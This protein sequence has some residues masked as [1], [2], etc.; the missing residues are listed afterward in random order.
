MAKPHR[1][2]RRR[3]L[4][5][6]RAV[7]DVQSGQVRDQ[8]LKIKERFQP[9]LG[10]FRLIGRVSRV[11]AGVFQNGPL[12][13][14]WGQGAVVTLADVAAKELVLRSQRSELGEG[15]AFAQSSGKVE[16]L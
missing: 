8:R 4:V 11:P 3:C 9:T 7:G 13:H 12:N 5:Q 2:R 15:G 1:L 14:G 6:Q 10:N 16:R